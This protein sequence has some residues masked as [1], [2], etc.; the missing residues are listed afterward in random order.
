[1]MVVILSSCICLPSSQ[2]LTELCGPVQC[3]VCQLLDNVFPCFRLSLHGSNL[4]ILDIVTG[5]RTI[6][7]IDFD[8]SITQHITIQAL[9]SCRVASTCLKVTA[10]TEPA[11]PFTAALAQAVAATGQRLKRHT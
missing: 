10:S 8:I 9:V 2:Q 6:H 5:Q 1:M 7:L 3:V 4:A 11:S